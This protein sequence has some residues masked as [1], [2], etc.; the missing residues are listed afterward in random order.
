[1]PDARTWRTLL[2]ASFWAYLAATAV[3]IGWVVAHEPFSF[4]AWNVAVDTG[5]RPGS[6]ARFLDY[7]AYEYTHS[8]PRI[9]QPITYL[10]YK[11][12][13]VAEVLTPLA[14]LA[15]SLAITVLGLGR[16]PRRG[17]ELALWA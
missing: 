4:D 16:W 3:H 2:I 7:W 17:R 9:G 10:V 13:Y 6:L 12:E 8:N 15:I 1:M 14:F 11:F 5:A